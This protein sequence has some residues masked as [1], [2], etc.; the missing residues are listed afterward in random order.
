MFCVCYFAVQVL[1]HILLKCVQC[2]LTYSAQYS[3]MLFFNF[4]CFCI[5]IVTLKKIFSCDIKKIYLISVLPE[6]LKINRIVKC[7]YVLFHPILLF[8]NFKKM[9]VY[10]CLKVQLY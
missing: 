7:I 4:F 1:D 3:T 8:I 5:I 10:L 2:H 9:M 6:Y